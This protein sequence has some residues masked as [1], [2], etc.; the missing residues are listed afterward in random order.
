LRQIGFVD[1]SVDF[2]EG[3]DTLVRAIKPFDA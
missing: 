2:R 3:V 1:L